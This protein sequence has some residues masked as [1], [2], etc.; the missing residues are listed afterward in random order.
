M[1]I[2]DIINKAKYI[3]FPYNNEKYK[4]IYITRN[5]V[6]LPIIPEG[7]VLYTNMPKSNSHH[8]TTSYT[9]KYVLPTLNK[10]FNFSYSIDDFKL[11]ELKNDLYDLSYIIP[12]EKEKYKIIDYTT[13][14]SFSGDFYTLFNPT[15][16]EEP[17]YRELYR[18]PHSCSRIINKTTKS[19]RTLMIS[20]DSQIIPSITPLAHYF[21][22]VWYFDNRTGWIRNQK[23]K[24]YEFQKEKFKSYSKSFKN[25]TF[26][27]VLIEC[28]CRDL[29]WYEYWNLQ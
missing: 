19:K 27:D 15:F 2:K 21:K 16:F 9:Y 3:Q 11:I 1:K 10:L 5:P 20:G 28:Y 25:I 4:E 24:E 12:K 26:T 8:Y 13:E 23:T 14:E 18:Y 7:G 29:D 17:L 6:R 22:E